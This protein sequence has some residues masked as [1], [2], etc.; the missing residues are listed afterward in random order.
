MRFVHF[1]YFIVRKSVRNYLL[2]LVFL[3]CVLAACSK[4]NS[5][6]PTATVANESAPVAKRH[7]AYEHS[8]D[9]ETEEANV[10]PVLE[11][12]SAACKA[13][14]DEGCVILESRLRTGHMVAADIKMRGEPVAIRKLLTSLGTRGKVI[15]QISTAED[16]AG[17][18]QDTAKTLEMLQDY[19]TKLEALR[20]RAG[21]DIDGLIRI[22][23][24][25]A[26]VQSDIESMAGKQAHLTQRV[27]T[28]ILS[29]HVTSLQS[30]SSWKEI[31]HALSDFATNL[32][33]GIASVI[34]GIAY[35]APWGV[36]IMFFIWGGRKLW[37]RRKRAK[38]NS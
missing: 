6:G 13:V 31:T 27:A 29:V 17:P 37:T 23:K 7:M 18:L 5:L 15:S 16:L 9:L 2:S 32:S 35:L 1:T 20:G 24:E 3:S 22:N 36:T 4:P 12:T 26:Q 10:A 19:R 25:L 33:S 34:T 28:E 30:V 38:Q 21:N 14:P 11:S 8:I